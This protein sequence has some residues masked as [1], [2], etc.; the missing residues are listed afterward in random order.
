MSTPRD[1]ILLIVHTVF[2][3]FVTILWTWDSQLRL[4]LIFTPRMVASCFSSRNSFP[5]SVNSGGN[6]YFLDLVNTMV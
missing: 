3:A 4:E 5:P 6:P 1:F 2:V